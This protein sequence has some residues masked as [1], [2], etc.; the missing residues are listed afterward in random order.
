MHYDTLKYSDTPIPHGYSF[1]LLVLV[2]F[3]HR[4]FLILI[5]TLATETPF[6]RH[7]TSPFRTASKMHSTVNS[8]VPRALLVSEI[9]SNIIGYIN[10][11]VD[12]RAVREWSGSYVIPSGPTLFALALTCRA[13]SEQ[14][15]D[16]LWEFLIGFEPLMR[17][18]GIIEARGQ[19]LQEKDYPIVS[20]FSPRDIIHIF[21]DG[22]DPNRSSAGHYWSLC[23]SG[24]MCY[25][26]FEVVAPC[27][28]LSTNPSI[29]FKGPDAKPTRFACQ[30]SQNPP[31]PPLT[32]PT[33]TAS[34]Y[35]C[36][37]PQI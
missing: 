16:A 10:A 13:F 19:G 15:L 21:H 28:I 29:F 34:S 8:T 18:A 31:N 20:S 33:S 7:N 26:W 5:N 9:L 2:D 35:L 37:F 30:T 4:A 22:T 6:Q 25:A 11:N 36:V 3:P 12:K 1:S 24:P 14:A 27:P 32:W 17:C 23:K